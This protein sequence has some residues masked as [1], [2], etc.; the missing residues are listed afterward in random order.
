MTKG[1]LLVNLG[2]PAAPTTEAVRSYL[3][4]FLGDPLVIQKPRILWLPILHGIILRVRPK[5]SAELYKKIWTDEGSPLMYYTVKQAEELQKELPDTLVKYAMTYGEPKI[6]TE[7]QALR[8]LGAEEITVIPL[9]PQ[10]SVTTTEPIIRQVQKVGLENVKIIHEFYDRAGY[11]ELLAKGIRE[12]WQKGN[13]DKL[14]LSYHGIPVEYVKKGDAYEAQCIDTTDRLAKVLPEI[15]RENMIHCYQS[16]FGPDEW[17]KPATS[18]ILKML[19]KRGVKK[20]LVVTPAFVSDCIET[21]EEILVENKEYFMETGGEV[22]DFVHPL[23]D[24]P[25]FAKFLTTI[26]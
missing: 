25:D 19:P 26:V 9:Y 2:T 16:K 21:L 13:Y 15:G 5:K 11:A 6:E 14:V 1:I 24:D 22:F 10:Y 8:E 3:S 20:V 12:K 4:E 18:D 17:L 23:N 7:L